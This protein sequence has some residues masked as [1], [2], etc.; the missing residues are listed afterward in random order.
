MTLLSRESLLVNTSSQ[1][2]LESCNKKQ[3][4][5]KTTYKKSKFN[6][7]YYNY[8][9]NIKQISSN[10]GVY[11]QVVMVLDKIFPMSTLKGQMYYLGIVE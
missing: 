1:R 6:Q 4:N 5:N 9:E 8:Y 2:F 7:K 11:V 10:S 3:S